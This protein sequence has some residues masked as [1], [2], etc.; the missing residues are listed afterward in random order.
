MAE[1][2]M[3]RLSDTMTE[4]SIA[5]WL[6][7]E[8]AEVS[9]GDIL[10]EIETD[11]A[12]MELESY[13][14]GTLTKIL[15]P[16]GTTVP[17]GA[18]LAIIGD[19]SEAGASGGVADGADTA[20]GEAIGGGGA[21]PDADADA[22]ASAGGA[23]ADSAPATGAAAVADA[24]S[25]AG[26]DEV[27]ATPLVRS[28]ARE[29]G[30]DLATVRGSGPNGRIIRADLEAAI[31]AGGSAPVAP[32]PVAPVPGAPAAVPT[33]AAPAPA[34]ATPTP[35]PASPAPVPAAA[36]APTRVGAAAEDEILPLSQMRRV[37]AQ[38]LSESAAAPHFHVT[39]VA[40][41]TA[42]LA[43]RAQVNEQL[44]TDGAKVS[45]TDLLI[46]ACAA[47]L[48]AHP[49]VN[50]SWAGDHIVRRGRVNVGVAVAL[51]EGLIV[52]VVRDAD[53]LTLREVSEQA[54]SLGERARAGALKLDEFTG[55]TFTISNL[56]MFGVTE[57]NAVINPPE[58]GILAV[59]AALET[60]V[61]RDGE[62]VVAKTMNLNLTVDHRVL[63]GAGAAT[64]LRDLVR[65]IEEPLRI[66]T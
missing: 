63:D 16:P 2:F 1:V 17:I 58:A 44:A 53:R 60:P 32:V 42:L 55:G 38:R 24:A 13:E 15:V 8:G 62:V 52:P 28:L 54:R 10:A 35:T 6:V 61:V 46:K 57:F 26:S 9:E 66:V 64:F 33:P 59:G 48:R 30:I 56:G 51:E 21:A 23:V 3:P 7:A 49:E 18:T 4:G 65:L 11:K 47:A 50:S 14:S 5:Q 43:F 41:V 12:V 34:S 31:A 45:V 40:D 22:D 37:T 19:P 25:G 29:R 27:R 36:P 20:G 39:M